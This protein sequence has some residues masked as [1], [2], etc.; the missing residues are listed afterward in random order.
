MLQM[1]RFQPFLGYS[2]HTL[3][4]WLSDN[5][6]ESRYLRYRDSEGINVTTI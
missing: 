2:E 1:R 5:T 6:E 3:L 4:S